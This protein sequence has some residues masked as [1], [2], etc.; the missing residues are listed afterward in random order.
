V[1]IEDVGAGVLQPM[2]N[3]AAGAPAGVA[4]LLN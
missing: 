3:N 4:E 2:A 1:T